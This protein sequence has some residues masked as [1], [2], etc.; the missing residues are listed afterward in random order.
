MKLKKSLIIAIFISLLLL[1]FYSKEF[2][3]INNEK[4]SELIRI[5]YLQNDLHQLSLWIAKEKQWFDHNNVTIETRVYKNGAYLMDGFAANEIDIGYLG[6]A[7][8]IIKSTNAKIPIKILAQV[9]NEGSAIISSKNIT[10]LEQ[11]K[12]K[13]I[14][15][16]GFATMQYFLTL[17]VLDSV[18]L[19]EEDVFF[20]STGSPAQME[21]QLSTGHIDAMV[22]WEPYVQSTIEK[23]NNVLYYSEDIINHHPCCVLAARNDFLNKNVNMSQIVL[24]IHKNATQFINDYPEQS[25]EL[26]A[27]DT[28]Y[29]KKMIL[30]AMNHI[31]YT[32]QLSKPLTREYIDFLRD[33]GKIVNVSTE[34]VLTNIFI[35][36]LS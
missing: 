23:G 22:A 18:G 15:V 30:D 34:D 36:G 13:T 19:K 31:E 11:L 28:G 17:K 24:D 25:A 27:N 20:I 8:A 3:R 35:D 33:K 26:F 9:N 21:L 6:I 29:D 12:G 7:P 16:P 1:I 10:S 5:G 4:K 32:T 2:S 14:A